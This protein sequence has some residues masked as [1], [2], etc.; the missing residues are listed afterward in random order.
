VSLYLLDSDIITLFQQRHPTVMARVA[1]ARQAHQLVVSA[2]TIDE[3]YGGWHARI[4]KARKPGE[5][6]DAYAGLAQAAAVFGSFSILPF[7]V[8][9]I[10]RFEAL[11]RLKLNVGPNDLRIAATALEAGGIVVTRNLKD[12]RRVPGVAGEDW[13]V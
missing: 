8:P 11:K 6:S 4:P 7:P 5:L 9:A 10:Q 12:F 3:S 13:S 1:A 2:I